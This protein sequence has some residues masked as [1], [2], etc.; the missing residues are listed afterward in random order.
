MT[1]MHSLAGVELGPEFHAMV[2]AIA[3]PLPVPRYSRFPVLLDDL[4]HFSARLDLV[5]LAVIVALERTADSVQVVPAAGRERSSLGYDWLICGERP[6]AE[7]T[8]TLAEGGDGRVRV[9]VDGTLIHVEPPSEQESRRLLE[10]GARGTSLRFPIFPS[11][12]PSL[13]ARGD[14]PDELVLWRCGLPAARFRLPGPVLAA[15]Y[16]SETSFE[17]LVALIEVDGELVVHIEGDQDTYLRK[18]RVPID[19]SARDEAA[20]DLSPL[21]LHMEEFWQFGV[22]FRRAGQWWTLRCA[23]VHIV[24]EPSNAALHQPESTPFQ[25]RLDGAGQVLFGPGNWTAGLRAAGWTVW[26][27]GLDDTVIPVPSGAYVLGLTKV[28]NRPALLTREGGTVRVRLE[29]ESRTVVEFAT[30]VV[31]HHHLPWIAVQR[32]AHLVEVLDVATGAVL[33]RLGTA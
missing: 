18:L 2:D 25:T 22:Y 16:V 32:S 30:P 3:E 24:L 27:P 29:K 9:T 8:V 13:V 6:S 28:A 19:F 12:G 17:M 21:Y 31:R 15:I 4:P 7:R 11:A 26:G 10:S 1:K 14:G 33:H 20:H 23:G 5:R